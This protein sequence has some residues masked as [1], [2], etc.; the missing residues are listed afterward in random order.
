V[1]DA[2]PVAALEPEQVL[3]LPLRVRR[4]PV[5]LRLPLRRARLPQAVVAVAV[6]AVAPVAA[7]RLPNQP[8]D[9]PMER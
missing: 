9:L 2:A 7:P 3:E 1:V 5:E 4:L 6:D 8:R